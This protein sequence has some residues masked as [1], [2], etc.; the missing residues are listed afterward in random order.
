MNTRHQQGGASYWNVMLMILLS[1]LLI[2]AI[3]V[4]WPS[5][6][7]DYLIGKT[8]TERLKVVDVKTEPA[9]LK[10]QIALQLDRN[11]I[12]DLKVDDI[13]TIDHDDGRLQ[14][15]TDYEVRQNYIAN[16]DLVIKFKR[17][18]DQQVIKTGE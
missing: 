10:S 14:V 15:H 18:F 12:R 8:I 11:N 9:D 7:D 5:Y 4:L 13:M 17:D 1:V 16:I 2:K 6:W 3:L